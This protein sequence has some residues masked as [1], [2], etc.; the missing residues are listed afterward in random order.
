[1][2]KRNSNLSLVNK[3]SNIVNRQKEKIAILHLDRR[4]ENGII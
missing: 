1:M 2:V 3:I 4:N